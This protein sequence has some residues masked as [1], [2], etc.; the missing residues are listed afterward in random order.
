MYGHSKTKD[1]RRKLERYCYV[2]IIHVKR[3]LFTQPQNIFLS[4]LFR[5][6][7][8]SQQN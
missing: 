7:S 2:F 3:I 1:C 8:W 4:V 5:T 6:V